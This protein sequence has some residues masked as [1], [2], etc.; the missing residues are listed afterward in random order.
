MFIFILFGGKMLAT[1]NFHNSGE[2][3]IKM[4]E[5]DFYAAWPREAQRPPGY[6]LPK[7]AR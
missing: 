4:L 1:S 2:N 6:P 3:F 7:C 5:M